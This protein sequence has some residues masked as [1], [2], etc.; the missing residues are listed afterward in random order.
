MGKADP[1]FHRVGCHL[2]P[3]VVGMWVPSSRLGIVVPPL[4]CVMEA[5]PK[6]GTSPMEDRGSHQSM[7][8]IAKQPRPRCQVGPRA[9]METQNW[10]HTK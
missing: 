7:E 6:P 10:A 4:A 8:A 1:A 2:G 5:M 9:S 3:I